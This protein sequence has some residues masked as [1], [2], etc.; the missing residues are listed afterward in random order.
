MILSTELVREPV[1]ESTLVP[2]RSE[3]L[4]NLH[5]YNVLFLEN[6]EPTTYAEA[7]ESPDSELWLEA[8]RSELKSMDDNQVWNLVD[9]PD[10]VQTI[11][12]KWI[13]KKKTNMDGNV[14]VHK[15]RLVAKGY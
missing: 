10:G 13:F 11:E 4:R 15:A 6:N 7:M 1:V 3:R 2:R 14:I 12:C 5:D 9:L 8:M